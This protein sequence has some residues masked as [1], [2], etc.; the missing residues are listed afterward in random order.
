MFRHHSSNKL[1]GL[2]R[3]RRA[4][5]LTALVPAMILSVASLSSAANRQ[6]QRQDKALPVFDINQVTHDFGNVFVSED[7]A[8]SFT[9]RNLGA[10]PLLLSESPLISGA[11][12]NGREGGFRERVRPAALRG[13]A[14]PYT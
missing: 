3:R 11:P 13:A 10:A 14:P 4:L 6:S 2:T 5:A 7:L 9:I 8:H 12:K 1:T